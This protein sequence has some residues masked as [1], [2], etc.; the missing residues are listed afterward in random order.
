MQ[1]GRMVGDLVA[2]N[3]LTDCQTRRLIVSAAPDAEG[4]A[5]PCMDPDKIPWHLGYAGQ[6]DPQLTIRQLA[7]QPAFHQ[8]GHITGVLHFE[9]KAAGG[10]GCLNGL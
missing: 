6:H 8:V 7:E 10:L 1:I 5:I 3:V 9:R 4:I 2:H